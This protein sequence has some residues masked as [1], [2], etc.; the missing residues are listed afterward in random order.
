MT[1]RSMETPLAATWMSG[2]VEGGMAE[3]LFGHVVFKVCV[4][5]PSG[6]VDRQL[7]RNWESG[8]VADGSDLGL[9]SLSAAWRTMGGTGT[10]AEY[11]EREVAEAQEPGFSFQ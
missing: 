6:D 10:W 1:S 4:I 9:I 7:D 8:G 2:G 5:C 3:V 11:V